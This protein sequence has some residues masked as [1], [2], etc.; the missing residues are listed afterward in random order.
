MVELKLGPPKVCKLLKPSDGKNPVKPKNDKFIAKM[1]TFDVT[2]SDEIVDLLVDDRKIIIPKGLKTSPL[3]QRKKKGFFKFH[4]FLD[5]KTSHCVLFRDLVQEALNEGM[6]K[7][8]DKAKAPMQVDFNPIQIK[9]INYVKPLECIMVEATKSP[10]MATKVSELEYVE[11]VRVVYPTVE[12]ELV[13]FLNR[14]KLKGSEV[15]LCPRCKVVFD[16]KA[17]KG[18]EKTMPQPS[19]GGKWPQS[20]PIYSFNKNVFLIGNKIWPQATKNID[21]RPIRLIR[22]LHLGN[23]YTPIT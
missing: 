2:N 12:E 8:V 20:R 1:Y 5:H 18:N 11:K 4:K 21:I 13:D 22:I 17:T 16:R 7:F 9:Y 19:M 3:E 15:M 6:L 14:C 10:D 23:G